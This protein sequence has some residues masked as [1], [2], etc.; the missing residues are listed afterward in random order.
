MTLREPRV[1]V[2]KTFECPLCAVR[3]PV[4][5]R[6]TCR[7]CGVKLSL[8]AQITWTPVIEETDDE[9]NQDEDGAEAN[10]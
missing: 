2:D 5:V 8:H 9:G 6:T 3:Q 1:E 10:S 7:H 4:A